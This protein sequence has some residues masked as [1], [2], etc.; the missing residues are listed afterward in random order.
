MK[1]SGLIE[2]LF[3]TEERDL[4]MMSVQRV[5]A[6]AHRGLVGDRYFLGTG[7]YSNHPAWGANVTLI[8][9]EAIDAVNLGHQADFT[10]AMLRRNIATRGVRLESL[11]GRKFRCGTALLLGTKPFPPCVHL[12]DLL[13]RRDVLRN[14]AYCCGI[15]AEVLV[16]GEITVGSKI[17]LVTG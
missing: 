4:P 2:H 8:S 3:I 11:L 13:G 1:T 9:C 12:A 5:E 16:D 14:F 10:P 17:E 7:F 6:I 15:G